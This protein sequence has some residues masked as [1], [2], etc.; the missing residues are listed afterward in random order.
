[1]RHVPATVLLLA[2]ISGS[3]ALSCVDHAS[4]GVASSSGG[5]PSAGGAPPAGGVS[6][7]GGLGGTTS[8]PGNSDAATPAPD[9]GA[10]SGAY[11]R[12]VKNILV[13]LAPT[14]DEV[15]QVTADPSQLKALINQWLQMPEYAQ[16]MER[17]FELAFQQTQVTL[18]DFADQSYPQQL[19]L[20]GTTAPLLVQNAEQSFARTM[21]QLLAQ[22][23]PMTVGMTTHTLM[24]TTALKELYAFL[25]IWEVDDNGKV[26]DRFK[27]AHPN[28]SIYAQAAAGPVALAD[29]LDPSSPNYMHFYDPDV[30]AAGSAVSGCAEDPIVYPSSGMALHYLLLGSLDGWKASSGTACPPYGGTANAPQLT[31]DDFNDWTLVTIRAPNSGELTTPFYD[32]PKLRGATELVL[33]IPRIGFFSTPA[34]FANWQTNIS[35]QMRVTLNQAFIVGLGAQVDGTDSTPAPGNPPPGLDSV[36]AASPDCVFCHQTLDP[37]RSIFSANYSWNYHNQL[38]AALIAQ[39]GMFAFQG[40][41]TAVTSMADFGNVL[42]THPLFAQAW[43]QKLCYYVNSAPCVTN[44]PEFIRVVNVFQDSGY[45]WNALVTEFLTSPLTTYSVDTKTLDQTG[46]VITVTRR[47]H[48]CAELNNR[49]GFDD[50]CGLDAANPKPLATVRLIA[51]GLPSDGYGRGSLAPVLPNQPTLFYRAGIENICEAVAAQVIDVPTA[52]QLPNVQQWSSSAAAAAIADFVSILMAL[53]KSDA[54][55]AAAATLL[56]SHF[57]AAK[58]A[59]ASA[60]DALKSTFVAACMSP[61]MTAIGL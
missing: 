26:T 51:A 16:K 3:L 29:A 45:S 2:I 5:S 12:K 44:D 54:R 27:Q 4:L 14:D 36:H 58:T 50:A 23:S 20:N 48:L 11:L 60:S 15:A 47:D 18:A 56:T 10:P 1:M 59:G 13:G 41:T 43:A 17:F 42:A 21:L 30:T 7:S 61:G 38:D 37:T 28:L 46:E 57:N 8:S 49:L 34:Y 31:T 55:S 39:K 24:L 33:S 19:D 32:I 35:N 22:G 25:D 6:N 9:A 53:P 40:V 52:K